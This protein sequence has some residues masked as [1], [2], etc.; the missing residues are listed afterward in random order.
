M[1]KMTL[2]MAQR[3][4]CTSG[5]HHKNDD[6]YRRFI[7]L[8]ALS[9]HEELLELTS[10]PKDQIQAFFNSE[11]YK[12]SFIIHVAKVDNPLFVSTFRERELGFQ[13]PF[14]VVFSNVV[15]A[16]SFVIVIVTRV[17]DGYGKTRVLALR[18]EPIDGYGWSFFD[19]FNSAKR[20]Q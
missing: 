9:P 13:L 10:V 12:G 2:P 7:F 3:S 19:K 11:S 4:A 17:R 14:V 15:S 6:A 16:P 8:G 1:Y 18:N 5:G 20:R